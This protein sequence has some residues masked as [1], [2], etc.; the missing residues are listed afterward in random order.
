MDSHGPIDKLV[1]RPISLR[2]D[3]ILDNKLSIVISIGRDNAIQVLDEMHCDQL[4]GHLV[5]V[6]VDELAEPEVQD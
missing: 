6:L 1:Q 5:V 3:L 2:Y 4:V